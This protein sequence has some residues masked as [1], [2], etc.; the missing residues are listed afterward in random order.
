MAL[1][2]SE[3]Y[4]SLWASCDALRGGMDASQYKDYV[5]VLLFVRYVSDKYAEQPNAAITIPPGA[6][7]QDMV[8]LKGKPDIGDQINKKIITPLAQANKLP[9]FPD[10]NDAAKLGSGK[11]MVDRLTNL[12]TIFENP[13]LDYSSDDVTGEN[14]LGGAFEYLMRHISMG[15]G[16][17]EAQF[18]TPGEIGQVM[19]R[20]L[21]V[22]R[23][24][25]D[26]TPTVYDP[27]CGS[28]SLLLKVAEEAGTDV[29]LYGQEINQATTFLAQ[30]NMIVHNQPSAQITQDNSLVRPLLAGDGTLK[31]FDYV[32]GSP[33]FSLKRWSAG[34]DPENDPHDR[35]SFGVPPISSGDY[36]FISHMITSLKPHGSMAVLV[37]PGVLFRGGSEGAIRKGIL[38]ADLVEAVIGLA[39]GLLFNTGI[40]SCIL[41]CNKKKPPERKGKVLFINANR[42]FEK[43]GTRNQL[44]TEDIT[45]IVTAFESYSDEEQ[46]SRVVGLDEIR[47]NSLNLN[48]QRYVDSSE[49]AGL[50]KQYFGKFDKYKIADLALEVNSAG[51]N[52]EFEEK[53]N[54]VYIHKI[55]GSKK[56]TVLLSDLGSHSDR[57]HQVVL[58]NNAINAYVAQFLNTRVGKQSLSAIASW[59]CIPNISKAS[60]TECIIALPSLDVQHANVEAHRKLNELRDTIDKIDQE[61][62]LNPTS[63]GE[64]QSK[65]DS[66]LQAAGELSQ[67][68]Y[69]R[70]VIRQGESKTVEFKETFDLNLFTKERDGK[71]ESSALKTI[72][73]FLNSEGGNL[74]VGVS[75]DLQIVGI[76]RELAKFYKDN[77]DKFLLHFKNKL[78]ARVGEEFYPLVNYRI[79]SVDGVKVVHVECKKSDSPCFL[80]KNDFYVRTNPATDKLEG[81]KILEYVKKHFGS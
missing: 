5:L 9:N 11:E 77:T 68:D 27:T 78:K 63:S 50:L 49:L 71:I 51:R 32:V 66:M 64:F 19:A 34:I 40:P 53:S 69:I 46:F 59:G 12:I 39:P 52:R 23:A 47:E 42:D 45:R 60:L 70:S 43:A 54:A 36:A 73:A 3:L 6:S 58:K 18:Y 8:A 75:D 48:V 55:A 31:T 38:E 26:S 10:F 1:K 81:P 65:L 62:S 22:G 13:A 56:A 16:K 28:G 24:K 21:G 67:A 35:F 74:L 20:V 15:S 76:G 79:V 29:S 80:D 17:G 4:S 61:L 41:V 14:V 30:M 2:E 37:P 44:R 25:L 7:F 72:V 57:Y 33:P